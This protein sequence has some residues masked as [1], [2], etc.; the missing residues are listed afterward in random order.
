VASV[1]K[2]YH[3]KLW[4]SCLCIASSLLD[5]PQRFVERLMGNSGGDSS[6]VMVDR[7]PQS[8]ERGSP[9]PSLSHIA[10][11]DAVPFGHNF[12][13][14]VTCHS[15]TPDI[16]DGELTISAQKLGARGVFDTVSNFVLPA[17]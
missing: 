16:V 7:A 17:F 8:T 3:L 14:L 6:V 1:L 9:I 11:A 10:I 13:Q 12:I 5:L 15:F 4:V 2:N